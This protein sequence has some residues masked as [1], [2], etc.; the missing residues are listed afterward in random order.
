MTVRFLKSAAVI[1][2]LAVA[3]VAY[4]QNAA[5]TAAAAPAD[6]YKMKLGSFTI[7][8]LSDGIF[9]LPTDQLLVERTPG[10]VKAILT[11]ANAP[12]LE[13]TSV[14]AYLIDTGS[15][16]ILVDSGSGSYFGPTLGR[17]ITALKAAGYKPEDI[18]EVLITHLH[19]DHVG[20]LSVGGARVFPNATIRMAQS[21]HDFWLD[22][23]NLTK[24]DAS[25]QSSFDAAAASLAPYSAAGRV[26]PFK[27]G[28]TIAPGVTAVSLPG[29]TAGHTGYRVES[30]GKTL[31]IWGDVMH[32]AVVQLKDPAVTIKFDLSQAEASRSRATIMADAAKRHYLVAGAHL[33]FPGIGTLSKAAQEWQWT[34]VPAT[35]A[36]AQ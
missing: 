5:P 31:L 1:A 13:P 24:V 15:R 6:F 36:S 2:S 20:G 32:V 35:P 17:A 23:A 21:E 18:D 34:P 33:H 11:A 28:E 30:V 25:V 7:V 8:A 9:S 26:K 22:K 10:E 19:P 27:P 14:N 3:P 4:A 29:H 12:T 16:R